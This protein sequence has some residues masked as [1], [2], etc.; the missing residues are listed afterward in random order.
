M[1]L[2]AVRSDVLPVIVLAAGDSRRMGR[3]KAILPDADGLPFV[4]RIVRTCAAAGLTEIVV[5]TGRQHAALE[6]A[7]AR[8]ALPVLPRLARNVDPDRG[9]L[10]SLW[11]GMDAIAGDPEALLMT[12]VDV[13]MVA[14]STI[15][16]VIAAWQRT[17]APIVRPAIGAQHGHPVLFDRR[18]FDALRRAPLSAG[19]KHVVREHA[20]A[21]VDVSVD[22]RGCVIDVDTPADYAALDESTRGGKSK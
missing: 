9:Q 16:A 7:L 2:R 15:A 17:R 4:V 11:V 10:S 21:I 22:D 8:A 14:P 19:A 13:P 20:S 6:A 5:V 12:L 18:L 1:P 3:P